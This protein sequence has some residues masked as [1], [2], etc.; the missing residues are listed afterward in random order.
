MGLKNETDSELWR[1][2]DSCEGIK[3]KIQHPS[4]M[5]INMSAIHP[6]REFD[7]RHAQNNSISVELNEPLTPQNGVMFWWG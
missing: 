7:Y 3:F 1:T 6:K 5:E 4:G 2:M